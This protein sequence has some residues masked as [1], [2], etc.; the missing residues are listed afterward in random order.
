MEAEGE[1]ELG[2]EVKLPV[3]PPHRRYAKANTQEGT[4]SHFLRQPK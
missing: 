3:R 2:T 1:N 4:R